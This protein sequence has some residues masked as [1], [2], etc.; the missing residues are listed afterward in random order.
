MGD[1]KQHTELNEYLKW[2]IND[3]RPDVVTISSPELMSIVREI[4]S[5]IPIH[6]SIIAGVKNAINLEKYLNFKP[7]RLVPHHDCGKDFVAL[8][9]LIEISNKHHTEVE[10]LST[11]SCLR[12]CSN[13][14]AH[15]KYLVQKN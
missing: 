7:S 10:L 2:V 14:E 6:I 9:E 15:Y 3:L 5:G 12:K 1:E 11:E 13:R 4:S 8:K